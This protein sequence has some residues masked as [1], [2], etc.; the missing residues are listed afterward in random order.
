MTKYP[1]H[2]VPDISSC[3]QREESFGLSDSKGRE[4]GMQINL[5]TCTVVAGESPLQDGRS[6]FAHRS[7]SL[8][9]GTWYRV[10]I[11]ATR[12]GTRYGASG[13]DQYFTTEAQRDA[14]IAKRRAA[15]LKRAHQPDPVRAKRL[16][17]GGLNIDMSRTAARGTVGGR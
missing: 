9:P 1:N 16:P 10:Y 6:Y 13:R 4:F 3:A 5:Y 17:R 8:E 14:Y 11:H 15:A 12:G 7:T 2:I